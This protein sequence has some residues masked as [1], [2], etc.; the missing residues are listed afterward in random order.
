MVMPIK[1]SGYTDFYSSKQHAT[2]V[3]TMFRGEEN[4]LLPNWLSMP[5]GYNGR[6]SSV[7]VSET[8]IRRPKGQV[9][10]EKNERWGATEKLDYEA[11]IA[12]VVGE[13]SEQGWPVKVEDVLEKVFGFVVLNDWSARDIQT[14]EYVPLGPFTS[15]Y[16]ATTISPWIVT[17]EAL[18]PFKTKLK[19]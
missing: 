5:I 3:G 15:K 13:A 7:V 18:E 16:F 1:V 4:A 8:E 9:K 17:R 2:N 19:A 14:W 6:A 11:E 12:A 10:D